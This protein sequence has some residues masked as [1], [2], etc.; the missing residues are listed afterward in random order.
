MLVQILVFISLY[1]VLLES[2]ELRQATFMLWLTDLSS[3]DPYYVLPVIM[4][5]SM[6]IQQKLNPAPMN[7]I[8][9]KV[10]SFLPFIFTAFFAFFPSGLVLYWVVNNILSIGQQ[11]YITRKIEN[12]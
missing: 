12:A 5:V 1:W 6:F 11:W 10:L 8:Q 4:G 3:K 9:A 2:V 7:P